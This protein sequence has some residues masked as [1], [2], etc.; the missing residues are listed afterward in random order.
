M[1]DINKPLFLFDQTDSVYTPVEFVE[2]TSRDNIQVRVPDDHWI[3][4]DD[5]LRIF[6]RDG[7]HYKDELSDFVLV[8]KEEPA[9]GAEAAPADAADTIQLDGDFAGAFADFGAI[10]AAVQASGGSLRV[11]ATFSFG[12]R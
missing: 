6:R 9:D 2:I 8:N 4:Q 1:I 10:I 12:G 7:T 5:P 11:S 3:G